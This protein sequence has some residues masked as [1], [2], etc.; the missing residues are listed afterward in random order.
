MGR[1]GAQDCAVDPDDEEQDSDP[2]GLEPGRLAC[3]LVEIIDTG[4]WG[5]VSG[6]RP[7]TAKKGNGLISARWLCAVYYLRFWTT[8]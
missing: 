5:V 6:N 1:H 3:L 4:A 7:R 8:P 2:D